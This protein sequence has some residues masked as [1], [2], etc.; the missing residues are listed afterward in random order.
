MSSA[1]VSR[2]EGRDRVYRVDPH[3][4]AIKPATRGLPRPAK[5]T[6]SVE[7]DSNLELAPAIFTSVKGLGRL[8]QQKL[9]TSGGCS[10]IDD[11]GFQ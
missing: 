10:P 9:C 5:Q 3:M 1:A 11:N 4:Y 8:V 7:P 6:G 2:G